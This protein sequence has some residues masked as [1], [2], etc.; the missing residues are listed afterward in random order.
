MQNGSV[1]S[2]AKR[3]ATPVGE[4]ASHFVVEDAFKTRDHGI[5]LAPYLPPQRS[6]PVHV[7]YETPAGIGGIVTGHVERTAGRVW[8][9][10]RVFPPHKSAI[11][12]DAP[13]FG[14]PP[15]GTRIWITEVVE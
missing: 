15:V 4:A 2:T 1:R 14:L 8:D 13:G 10:G 7:R 6:R 5:V 9:P 12:I 3:E 11:V